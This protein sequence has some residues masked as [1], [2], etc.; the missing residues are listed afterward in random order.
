M[1]TRPA[2]DPG[3]VPEGVDLVLLVGHRLLPARILLLDLPRSL[4]VVGL[5]RRQPDPP[6]R[7]MSPEG[8]AS[9]LTQLTHPGHGRTVKIAFLHTDLPPEGEGG[10]A[11]QVDLLARELGKRHAL[12]VY[13]TSNGPD[14]PPYE[15]ISCPPIPVGRVKNP[16]SSGLAFRRLDLRSFD[17]V[18]AHGDSWAVQHPRVIRTFYG[19]AVAEAFSATSTRRRIGQTFQYGLELVE[20]S[21]AQVRTTIGH[22]ATRYYPR[23]DHVIPCGVD[24]TVFF[25]SAERFSVPTVLFVAGRLGGRKRGRLALEVFSCV[26]EAIPEAR[27]IVVSRDKTT[28][29]GVEC[30]AALS[31]SEMGLLFR[32]SWVLLS[33]STY[34]GFG[35]PYAEALMSGLPVLTSGNPGARE[36]LAFGGGNI[37]TDEQ[38]VPALINL[39]RSPITLDTPS[40]CSVVERFGIRHVA[41]EYE[42]IYRR[43]IQQ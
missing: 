25:P 14:D 17:V 43:L 2:A 4:A 21:R 7:K 39:L 31:H 5:R 30:R 32:R 13:T 29:P 6:E 15:A 26:R 24:T 36:V 37:V 28:R 18:H 41:D 23:I 42:C 12:T 3:D 8:A 38:L 40:H 34:E 10:V 9:L 20:W 35:L 16:L 19:S 22:H 27:L 1:S 33:T 11:Y